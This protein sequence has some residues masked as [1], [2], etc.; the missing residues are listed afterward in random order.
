M[1][2]N[3]SMKIICLF[4]TIAM[5]P[6]T[7]ETKYNGPAIWEMQ[8]QSTVDTCFKMIRKECKL[9]SL[10]RKTINFD[11]NIYRCRV[12]LEFMV[13]VSTQYYQ[14][15]FCI[16]SDKNAFNLFKWN[17][18]F[19]LLFG[20]FNGNKIYRIDSPFPID[21]FMHSPIA[22]GPSF[23]GVLAI[24]VQCQANKRGGWF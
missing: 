1:A 18:C 7:G 17:K 11:G 24:L 10:L 15:G 22:F 21:L 19:E 14:E 9:F 13:C 6:K 16:C 5:T 23:P 20:L 8:T 3:F 12:Q 4:I 2:R